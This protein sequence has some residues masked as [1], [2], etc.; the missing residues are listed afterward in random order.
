MGALAQFNGRRAGLAIGL[1]LAMLIIA[2]YVGYASREPSYGGKRLSKWL[3]D[4]DDQHPGAANDA[5]KKAVRHI[6]KD[7][8][9]VIIQMLQARDSKVRSALEGFLAKLPIL[10]FRFTPPAIQHQRAALACYQLGGE[11]KPAIPALLDCLNSTDGLGY[12]GAALARMG[13]DG[14]VALSTALT[15]QNFIVRDEAVSSLSVLPYCSVMNADGEIRNEVFDSVLD[16][17]PARAVIPILLACCKDTSPYVRTRAVRGLGEIAIN[18]ASVVPALVECVHDPDATTRRFACLALGHFRTRAKPAVPSLLEALQDAEANVRRTA[19]IAL[20]G[21]EPD[22]MRQVKTLMPILIENLERIGG[23]GT[24]LSF[25][26]ETVR[27]IGLCGEQ[28]KPAVPALL[29]AAHSGQTAIAQEAVA[30]LRRIDPDAVEREA[31]R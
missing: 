28:A 5:A 27:V 21:I 6:G 12:F 14:V 20:V 4:L 31:L 17:P 15:N 1:L 25:G 24:N 22:N 3:V 2:G 18:E 13:S 10:K 11:A 19:A 26:Y 23:T 29:K 7:G 30:A 9:P 8:L 16:M